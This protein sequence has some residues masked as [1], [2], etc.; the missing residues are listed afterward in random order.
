MADIETLPD[1][2]RRMALNFAARAEGHD[3]DTTIDALVQAS[4]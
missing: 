1:R 4:V 3:I 2:L